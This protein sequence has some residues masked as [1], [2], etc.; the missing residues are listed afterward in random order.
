MSKS[1]I[2]SKLKNCSENA[3]PEELSE[4]TGGDLKKAELVVNK[5]DKL[6]FIG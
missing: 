2:Y 4:F 1:E 6:C 5:R 3:G